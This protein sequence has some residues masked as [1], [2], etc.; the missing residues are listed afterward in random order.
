MSAA[1][2]N[3]TIIITG[4]SSG[5]GAATARACAAAGMDVLLHG[6]QR[7]P[8]EELAQEIKQSGRRAGVVQGDVSEPG[9]STRLLDVA[10]ETLD[11]FYAVFANAGYGFKKPEHELDL[12][13]LRRLFDVNFFSACELLFE[14]ARRLLA[15]Q[16]RGH[17]LMCSSAVAKFTM[18]NFGAYSATKA[19]Q[20]HICRAMRMELRPHRIAVS[21][22]HPI[23][24]RTEFFARAA[25]LTGQH[26]R[27]ADAY[28]HVPSFLV[29]SPDLVARAVV[30]CLR[31]PRA[32]VWTSRPA[33]WLGGLAN[34]FPSLMDFVGTRVG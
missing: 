26:I 7:G 31:R 5:I 32:E 10:D 29:Q 19:A 28:D 13:E 1:L 2:T 14:A 20:N 24:T 6:R 15:R 30:R 3:R 21:S 16:E 17:L 4:A 18:M 12:S 33:R 22:V 9:M 34:L 27:P 11:G 8:L 25:S 23:T